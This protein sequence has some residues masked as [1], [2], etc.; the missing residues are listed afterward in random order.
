M[1]A[2]GLLAEGRLNMCHIGCQRQA[3]RRSR[4]ASYR[5]NADIGADFG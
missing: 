4:L 3:G 1:S 5:R 2:S